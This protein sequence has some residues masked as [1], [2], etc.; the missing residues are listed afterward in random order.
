ML[1]TCVFSPALNQP[2]IALWAK[3]NEGLHISGVAN[4]G[5][6]IYQKQT[7]ETNELKAYGVWPTVFC[8]NSCNQ[9]TAVP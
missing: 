7:Y 5:I 9:V 8:I 1:I 4:R 6:K 2:S 3:I